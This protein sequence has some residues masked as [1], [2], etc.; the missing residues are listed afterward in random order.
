MSAET[1]GIKGFWHTVKWGETISTIAAK[2]N[3]NPHLLAGVN[4]IDNWDYIYAGERLWIPLE[5]MKK[6]MVYTVK[7]NDYLLGIAAKTGVSAW[8][9]ARTNG[10]FN[11]NMIYPGQELIIPLQ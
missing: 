6:Y 4:N 3:V 7:T 8:L 2:Y 5:N 10:L 11:L 9:I 1:A